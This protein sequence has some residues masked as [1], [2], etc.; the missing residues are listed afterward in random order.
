MLRYV[1][2]LAF[3][4]CWVGISYYLAIPWLAD[5]SNEVGITFAYVS[6]TGIAFIPAF[7][8]AFVYSTLITDKRHKYSNIK[9]KPI[10]IL[11]AAYNEEKTIEKTLYSIYNQIYNEKI[12]VIV[13]NDGSK[14]NTQNVVNHFI[15]SHKKKNVEFSIINLAKNSGKSAALNA[16][17]SKAKYDIIVTLDADSMLYENALESIVKTLLSKG[18]NTVAVAGT[19]LANNSSKNLITKIQHWDYLLGISSVKQSQSSYNGTLV[20]QGAFSVYTKDALLKIGGWKHTVGEDIVLSWDLLAL[21]YDIYHDTNAVV[22]TNVPTSYKQYFNQRKRWAR[23]LI[24]AFKYNYRMLYKPRKI[25]PFIW[26][27][28]MFPFIDISFS[29]LFV[30]SI[31]AAIAFNYY[32]LAG[33]M[34]LLV[35]PIAILINILIYF[36]QH[37]TF[38][39]LNIKMNNNFIGLIL[40][41]LFYQMLLVPATISGYFSEILNMKKSWGTK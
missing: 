5:V 17:L 23:G 3:S 8:M 26:Y 18:S 14:D 15:A 39:R 32:L 29:F 38:K 9:L 7:A 16:G 13:C 30:P 11:V 19:V 25:L 34:T 33:Y 35:L 36:I 37:R 12:E 41:V 20:A 28:L 4:I 10:T 24:E 40:F 21:G 2:C 6:I 1:L 27:N 31:I 22:F